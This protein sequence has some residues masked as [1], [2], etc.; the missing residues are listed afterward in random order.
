[1][2]HGTTDDTRELR[3]CV[4]DLIAVSALSAYWSRATIPAVAEGLA[5]VMLRSVPAEFV[6]VRVNGLTAGAVHDVVRHQGGPAD[7]GRT[8]EL[9]EWLDALFKSG[10]YELS[11]SMTS[12]FGE[13]TVRVAVNSIGFEGDAGFAA[14][15]SRQPDFP[16]Q[17]DKLLLNAAANQAAVI[18]QHRRAEATL[19]ESEERFARFMQH[20]PGL[21]WIK[22]AR[23]RYLYANDAAEK[24]FGMS[25]TRLHGKTDDE[26]FPPEAAAQFKANDRKALNGGGAV[27]VV[28]TL[29]HEDG[30]QRHLLV[31]KFAIPG[32]GG[33][34]PL[35]GGVA[36]D[37]TDR[38]RAE[39]ALRD[40]DRRKDEFLATL[41][42]EL[43][44]PL[45][46]MSNGLQL[47]RLAGNNERVLEQARGMMER[48]L[49]QMVRL[50]DDLLDVSRITRGKLELRKEW[51][52]LASVLHNAVETSRPL[53]EAA[54]HELQVAFPSEPIDLEADRIRMAQVFANVLNNAAKYTERGGRIWLTAERQ[55]TSAVV[56][57]RDN[58]VGIPPHMLTRIFEM[59]TQVDH[60]LEK[61]H[62]G[63]G[64]GL[65]LVKRLV[66]MHGGTVEAHSAGQGSGSEF[67]LCLP[68]RT[69][70]SR[71]QPP[72]CEERR[73]A[74]SPGRRLVIADDNKD[75]A[76]S[77]A[78][79]LRLTG[80]DV[81][82]AH[83]GMAAVE[84]ATSFQPEAMLLDIGMPRL[85][86]YE[87]A[88][89]IRQQ[90]WGKNVIL[91]ALTGW[92]QSEDKQR[93]LAAGFDHHMTKP[94]DPVEL[95]NL[96][97]A[98]RSR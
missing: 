37:I 41:A 78:L 8:K 11:T 82:T 42:H 79:M 46:P 43:R 89:H 56:K 68:A 16:T 81:R 63:L 25:A 23:G 92:G 87:A 88:R 17:I 80:N 24:A 20:L 86:G 53:V 58:G 74:L 5:D 91:I 62:G 1:M 28:E 22:D 12:R 73:A 10:M 66:E 76:E 47:L 97:A 75:S 83:D 57:V 26:I 32:Q 3:R 61:K 29:E 67:V 19:R 95:E 7:P 27:Q 71:P 36:I 55:G 54:G 2:S 35:V 49:Q 65:T 96:L 90:P 98:K 15:G 64:I 9:A 50:I 14:A 30:A 52:E 31:S 18:L 85:N 40:A 6:F 44:N 77:L 38:L 84:A 33:D 59:F 45:A 21:A 48:Q 51:V 93:A 4:R 94:V 70:V 72:V 13:G 34:A 69:A 39:E 60:S